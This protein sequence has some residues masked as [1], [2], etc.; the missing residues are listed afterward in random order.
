VDKNCK[1]SNDA[2]HEVVQNPECEAV[3]NSLKGNVLKSP[4]K[5]L[6]CLK[7]VSMAEWALKNFN[8]WRIARNQKY[9]VLQMCWPFRIL[10]NCVAEARKADGSQYT[11]QNLKML[12]FAIQRQLQKINPKIQ[13]NIISGS[14]VLTFKECV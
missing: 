10:K 2:E 13:I 5:N 1:E 12:L 4:V 9:S 14:C 8:E 6:M 11:P 7:N 3:Q